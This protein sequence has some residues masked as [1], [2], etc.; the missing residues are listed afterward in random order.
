MKYVFSMIVGGL[1]I[2]TSFLSGAV[3]GGLF[4]HDC[5]E[6]AVKKKEQEVHCVEV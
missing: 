6:W 2:M 4:V 3:V 5:D 1:M